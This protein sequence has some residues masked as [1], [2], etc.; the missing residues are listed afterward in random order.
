[1]ENLRFLVNEQ[2]IKLS[3]EAEKL[4]VSKEKLKEYTRRLQRIIE[5]LKRRNYNLRR[6]GEI[7]KKLVG[8][9]QDWN[10]FL[11]GFAL[12]IFILGQLVVRLYLLDFFDGNDTYVTIF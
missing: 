6:R 4:T 7:L 11:K 1:M 10:R 5:E 8:N 3:Q 2:N 9:Y 12:M